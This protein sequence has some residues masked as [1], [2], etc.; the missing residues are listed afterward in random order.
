MSGYVYQHMLFS[1][2]YLCY[3]DYLLVQYLNF[4]HFF[5][6]NTTY[7]S[8]G[9]EGATLREVLKHSTLE[10]AVMIEI[11]K[12]V[13]ELS[14]DYLPQWQDC[15]SIAHHKH[16][17]AAEWCF[18]DARAT[19]KF[20]DAMKYF[21]EFD[22]KAYDLIIMDALDPNDDIPFAVEL[23]TSD[24][25][26]RSLFNALNQ[27][28]ILVVQVGESPNEDRPADE[29][30]AFANRAMMKNKLVEV[31]FKRLVFCSS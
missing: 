18:D 8:G 20:D 12:E 9:G 4:A 27:D 24:D 2:L 22:D 10:E 26:I 23:Y 19:T 3:Y 11:D 25:Y 16:R 21:I 31:G 14:R 30:G 1:T 5:Y 15:S 28:G 17:G 13:V 7:N 29:V 6:H